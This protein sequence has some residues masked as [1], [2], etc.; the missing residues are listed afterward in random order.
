M[1]VLQ[2]CMCFVE[3]G[4]VLCREMCVTHDDG[5]EEVNIKVEEDIDIKDELPE[6]V[7][8]PP[9]KTENEVRLWGVCEV[10]ATHAFMPFFAPK[11]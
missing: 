11:R 4:T 2:D 6:A 3:D 8:F 9:I 7:S 5:T 1:A 10:V